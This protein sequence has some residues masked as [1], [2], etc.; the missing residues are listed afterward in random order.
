VIVDVRRIISHDGDEQE[1]GGIVPAQPQWMHDVCTN[2]LHEGVKPLDTLIPK[3]KSKNE[4][5]IKEIKCCL[6]FMMLEVQCISQL[7]VADHDSETLVWIP[8]FR[9]D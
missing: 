1:G 3:K 2:S 7:K 4:V 8:S 9:N 6:M 5:M